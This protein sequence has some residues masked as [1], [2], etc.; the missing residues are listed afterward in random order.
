MEF[1]LK[2]ALSS[3]WSH[4]FQWSC[5]VLPHSFVKKCTENKVQFKLAYML[6]KWLVLTFRGS[7]FFVFQGGTIFSSNLVIVSQRKAA[8]S[9]KPTVSHDTWPN[10]GFREASSKKNWR[11]CQYFLPQEV[12]D[13]L[14]VKT[15]SQN[16]LGGLT[17]STPAALRAGSLGTTD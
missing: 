15:F 2:Q 8:F 3:I 16:D 4:S 6:C 13:L 14:C 12:F 9:P 17:L 5:S 1:F 7:S 10:R 11:N